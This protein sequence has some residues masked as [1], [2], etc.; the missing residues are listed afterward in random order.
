MAMSLRCVS[1]LPAW[2]LPRLLSV[3]L[4]CLSCTMTAHDVRAAVPRTLSLQGVV[5]DRITGLPL[6]STE[7]VLFTL[8]D[9]STNGGIVLWHETKTITFVEG[10]YHVILGTDQANP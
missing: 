4:I 6:N 3:W 8:Y 10:N 1:R 9:T 7:Q 5:T 2:W